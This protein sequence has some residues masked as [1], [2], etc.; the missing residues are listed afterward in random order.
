MQTPNTLTFRC[1]SKW[2][3]GDRDRQTRETERWRNTEA[4]RW[5]ESQRHTET[6]RHT[7]TDK[8]RFLLSY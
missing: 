1:S 2:G 3:R 8:E 7:E 5:R 6:E 4:E